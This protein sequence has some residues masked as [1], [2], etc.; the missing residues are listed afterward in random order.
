[1]GKEAKPLSPRHEGRPY[2]IVE[3]PR[4]PACGCVR[5]TCDGT[6]PNGDGTQTRYA[7]CRGCGKKVF[8]VL[9]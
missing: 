4:C 9:E 3:R 8:I 2:I 6:R 5:F 7:R 1:M